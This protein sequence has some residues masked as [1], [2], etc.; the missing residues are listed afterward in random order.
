M[1]GHEI[2][3]VN[4]AVVNEAQSINECVKLIMVR[5]YADRAL[6]IQDPRL[7]AH[8][9]DAPGPLYTVPGQSSAPNHK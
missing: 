6:T 9:V 8:R 2:T 3:A 1:E 5:H 7:R 4:G